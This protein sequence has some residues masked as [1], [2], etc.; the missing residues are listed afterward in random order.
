MRSLLEFFVKYFDFVYLDP[1]YRITDSE[2]GGDTINASLTLTGPSFTWL[3]VNDRGQMQLSLAPTR[4]ATDRNWFWV[5]LIKQ[6]MDNDDEIDYLSAPEEIRWMRENG[7]RVEQLFSDDSTIETT[8][9]NLKALRRTNA[10]KY[11]SRWREQQG[12]T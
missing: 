10:N 1:R 9:D 6:Y 3:L 4:L 7:D 12:L 2:T 5:S 11:W 8:C